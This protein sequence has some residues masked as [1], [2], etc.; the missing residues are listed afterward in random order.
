MIVLADDR[1]GL[2]TD[3]LVAERGSFG[4]AGDDADVLHEVSVHRLPLTRSNAFPLVSFALWRKAMKGV[5]AASVVL[6][7][8]SAVAGATEMSRAD[9]EDR[10]HAAWLGQ[11]VGALVAFPHEHGVASAVRLDRYP[12]EYARAPVDD[13]WYY[14]MVAVRA[15]ERYGADL[16]VAELGQQWRE[17]AAGSWGSSRAARLAMERGVTPP[18]T[19]HPSANPLWWT[20]GPQFSA[21]VYGLVAPGMP[22]LAGKLARELGAI[23][24]YAEGLDGAV[25]VAGMVSL[26]FVERDTAA[27]VRQAAELVHP[28]SPYRQCLDLVVDLAGKGRGM[29]EIADAV[30]DRWHLEYPGTNNALPN[31][32]L[33]AAGVWL[34]KGDVMATVNLL[35]GAAD[36]TDADC[37]AA[38]AAAVAAVISGTR[39]LPEKLVSAL[40]DRIRG[41]EMGGVKVTPPVDEGI[42]E[43]ARRTARVGYAMIEARGGAHG[44]RLTP[45][46]LRFQPEPVATLPPQRFTLA[47]LGRLWNP[48]W[49]LERAGFGG[50]HGGIGGIRGM[51]HLRG[52]VLATYPRDEVR[53]LL[54][55]RKVRLGPG[56]ALRIEV[57]VDPGRAFDLEVYA[58]NERLRRERIELAASAPGLAFTTIEEGLSRFTGQEVTLRIYQRVLLPDR[59]AGNAYWKTLEV[60]GSGSR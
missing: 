44:T 49:T 56:A 39:G 7:L 38:N 60:T 21:D 57:G 22:N 35:A 40:G 59:V 58:D 24:G 28:E 9:Y 19:G 45:A 30:E 18:A 20:I 31:G 5:P 52:K 17:N 6:A 11:I 4:A 50:G 13:D 37:N 34:G 26:A 12:R 36:F 51:T 10:V 54:F 3:G 14:E 33:V 43:L 16:T 15:F 25:F 32:C 27:V 46:A 53:G 42:G 2:A 47:D 41:D 1:E 55:R 8:L 23:N 48:D 29:K